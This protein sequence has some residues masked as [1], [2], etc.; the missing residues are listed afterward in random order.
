MLFE[1]GRFA[2]DGERGEP[3]F[4]FLYLRKNLTHVSQRA[5]GDKLEIVF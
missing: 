1:S 2:L 4:E 3:G 5:H